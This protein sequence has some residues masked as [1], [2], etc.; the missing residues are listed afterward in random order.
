M[1]QQNLR[2]QLQIDDHVEPP[3]QL[4]KRRRLQPQAKKETMQ[5]F[6]C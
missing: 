6:G 2:K 1:G 3:V 4:K 5:P